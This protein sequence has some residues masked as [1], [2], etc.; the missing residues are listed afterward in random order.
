MLTD[1]QGQYKQRDSHN[2]G[3]NDNNRD[4]SS[5][6]EVAQQFRQGS[7]FLQRSGR[8]LPGAAVRWR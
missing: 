4:N 5:P 3:T 1:L 7:Y 2:A 6:A 8:E